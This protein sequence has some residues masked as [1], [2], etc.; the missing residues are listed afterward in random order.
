MVLSPRDAKEFFVEKI[1]AQAAAESES[2]SDLERW[3]LGFSEEDPDFEVDPEKLEKFEEEISEGEYEHRVAGLIRRRYF[4]D[5]R[6]D[7]S[8]RSAY[9]EA[10]AVLRRGDYTL[11]LSVERA[12]GGRLR[13]PFSPAGVGL[14]ILC[15][16]PAL[17]AVLMAIG[18]VWVGMTEGTVQGMITG[19]LGG[20]LLAG[21]AYYLVHLWRR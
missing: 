19:L 20:L 2:L 5:V 4:A 7:S 6:A 10:Y 1:N 14:A 11:Q 12:L 21:L 18:I 8:A 15:L 13:D 17:V 3:M 16:V 9:R